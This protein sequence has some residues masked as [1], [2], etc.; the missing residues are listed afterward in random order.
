MGPGASFI[1]AGA[2]AGS[3]PALLTKHHDGVTASLPE[4]GV[5]LP[6]VQSPAHPP[7]PQA[8]AALHSHPVPPRAWLSALQ[9]SL[10]GSALKNPPPERRVRSLGGE[11]AMEKEMATRSSI[12]AWRIPRTEEPGGLQSVGAAESDK[13]ERARAH[14]HARTNAL[15]CVWSTQHLPRGR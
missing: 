10:E 15:R 12:L 9:G 4:E 5:S 3:H 8:T 14:T 13:A 6:L 1:K 11:D 7:P 2:G